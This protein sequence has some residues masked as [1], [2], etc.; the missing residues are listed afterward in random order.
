MAIT[1]INTTLW[2]HIFYTLTN[3]LPDMPIE[4]VRELATKIIEP[5]EPD[6]QSELNAELRQQIKKLEE[7]N[8]AIMKIYFDA[9]RT[10][11]EIL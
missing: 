5:I 9:T 2:D 6:Y 8:T 11:E 7:K 4:E 1:K 3:S 10:K